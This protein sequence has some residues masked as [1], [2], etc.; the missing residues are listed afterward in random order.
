MMF[1]RTKLI[2]LG[3]HSVSAVS[4]GDVFSHA[5]YSKLTVSIDMFKKHIQYLLKKQYTFLQFRDIVFIQ[6]GERR[7]PKK[8]VVVYFDDGYRDVFLHVYP[9]LKSVGVPATIFLTTDFINRIRLPKWAGDINPKD[10]NI[11]LSWSEICA[12][13][14]VF[15]IGS[16]GVT[17]ERFTMLDDTAVQWELTQS[18]DVIEQ[19]TGIRPT[20]CSLPHSAWDTRFKKL[21]QKIGYAN[22]VGVAR[23]YNYGPAYSFL[24]KIPVGPRDSMWKF[25]W[26]LSFFLVGEYLR[27]GTYFFRKLIPFQ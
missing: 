16:H 23:G 18:R 10:A 17:H 9:F 21:I 1:G 27:R 11:F 26:K 20:A 6:R 13:K 7:M 22:T 19:Y 15:E 5:L 2:A 4:N 24:K 3:Y 14:D 25:R 12:M 8:P